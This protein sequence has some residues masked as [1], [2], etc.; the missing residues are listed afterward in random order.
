[1][2]FEHVRIQSRAVLGAVGGGG[3]GERTGARIEFKRMLIR[4]MEVIRVNYEVKRRP[5]DL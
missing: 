5:N 1:M 4:E 2:K 3:G